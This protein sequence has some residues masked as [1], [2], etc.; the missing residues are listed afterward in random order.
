MYIYISAVSDTHI[1]GCSIILYAVASSM[2]FAF[3]RKLSISTLA[4]DSHE[5]YEYSV[6]KWVSHCP[7]EY[8]ISILHGTMIAHNIFPL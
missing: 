7:R 6:Y 8:H 3:F 2:V 4:C 1:F 5:P